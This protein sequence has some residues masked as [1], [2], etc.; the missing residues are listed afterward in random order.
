MRYIGRYMPA[1]TPGY[2]A[3]AAA[4]TPGRQAALA[5][6]TGRVDSAGR[7][8]TAALPSVH[9]VAKARLTRA[10]KLTLNDGYDSRSAAVKRLLEAMRVSL[11]EDHRELCPYCSLDSTYQL[12]HFLPKSVYPEFSLYGP[13]LL[14]ICGRC[15]QIKLNSVATP[16]G[17]RIFVLPS[18][19]E[20]LREDLLLATLA[21]H[22]VPRFTFAIDPAAPITA[23]ERAQVERHF[24]RLQ[25]AS[26]YRRR[27][28]AL[29][30][31]WKAAVA[32][33]GGRERVARKLI[34]SGLR[35]AAS[36]GPNNG[37]ELAMFR[38][39]LRQR[40]TFKQWLLA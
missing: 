38:A 33:G 8:Y 1:D 32:K 31:P 37:W 10:E 15:N 5:A 2:A 24:K 23:V 18:D 25:L 7:R 12:D 17:N 9:L 27:A 28:N 22:P 40:H 34:L 13:N 21:M 36:T 6:L 26:R 3:L 35:V 16:A 20:F 29:L 19:D 11:A 14:P 30:K 4:S 39:I